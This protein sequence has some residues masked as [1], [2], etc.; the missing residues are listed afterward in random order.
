MCDGKRRGQGYIQGGAEGRRCGQGV[1]NYFRWRTM[2]EMKGNLKYESI[3]LKTHP[4]R[5]TRGICRFT[6]PFG[7]EVGV[8][9]GGS[10]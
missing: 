8:G 5:K 1:V 9:G 10:W 2:E 7:E 6:R 4:G 3:N